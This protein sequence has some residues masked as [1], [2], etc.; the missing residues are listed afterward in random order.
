M[1]QELKNGVYRLVTPGEYLAAGKYRMGKGIYRQKSGNEYN[2]YATLTGLAKKKGDFLSVVA[3]QGGYFPNE[4]DT[5]IG[6]ITGV[7][8]TSWIV[9]IRSYYPG[10]LS[11]N[12]VSDRPFDPMREDLKR[13]LGL[14]DLIMARIVT[15]D[16]TRDPV[17]TMRGRGLKKLWN[18][19]LVEIPPV[20]IARILGKRGSMISLIK[21][22]TKSQIF[23]GMNGRAL[24][25]S[26]SLEHELLVLKVIDKIVKEAHI[27]GL[28]NRVQQFLKE[29]MSR[30]ET[31]KV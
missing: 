24:I 29:E 4:G 8:V 6:K 10:V 1:S 12:S 9:D 11:V 5:V 14:G 7:G 13:I 2:Y 18:G 3:L 27:S 28:T 21:K 20:K 22:E 16:R 25:S 31:E 15:F 30:L 17:L 23:L 26:P 19:R